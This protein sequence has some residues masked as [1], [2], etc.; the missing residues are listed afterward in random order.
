M[1]D[2]SKLNKVELPL[3]DGNN[4]IIAIKTDSNIFFYYIEGSYAHDGGGKFWI[5]GKLP[6][7]RFIQYIDS[8]KLINSY[9]WWDEYPMLWYQD[10]RT[11]KNEIIIPYREEFSKDQGELRFTWDE[12]AQWFGVEKR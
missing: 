1:S 3:T 7:G 2:K 9:N 4:N 5:Y 10:V 6:D 8:Q 11:E 12:K